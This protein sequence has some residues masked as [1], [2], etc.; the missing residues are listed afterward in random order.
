MPSPL[1]GEGMRWGDKK[2]YTKL[3]YE[4]IVRKLPDKKYRIIRD[5]L[6]VIKNDSDLVARLQ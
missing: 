6:M 1:W 4:I 2:T 3:S 5:A